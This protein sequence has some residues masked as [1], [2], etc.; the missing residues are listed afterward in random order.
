[1]TSSGNAENGNKSSFEQIEAI[2]L[3]ERVVA[4]MKN[5]FFPAN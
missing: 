1:V 5:A 3:T 4:A 2:S